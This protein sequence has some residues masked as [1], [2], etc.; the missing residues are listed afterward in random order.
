VKKLLPVLS[1]AQ[2]KLKVQPLR[3]LCK[4]G[5]LES[6]LK[7]LDSEKNRVSES[8]KEVLDSKEDS[9]KEALVQEV[10]DSKDSVDIRVICQG[11]ISLEDKNSVP[12]LKKAQES[13]TSW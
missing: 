8:T 9:G 10:L 12:A 2:S 5:D 11:E 4:V 3:K 13:Q 1:H 7:A 6:A